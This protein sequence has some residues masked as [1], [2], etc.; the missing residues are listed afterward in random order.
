[1]RQSKL[2]ASV[3]P[4]GL[5]LA[6]LA[7]ASLLAAGLSPALAQSR[8]GGANV[9]EAEPV[10]RYRVELIFFAHSNATTTGE[11]LF[12]GV[13]DPHAPPR[14]GLL[15]MP[16]I[17]LDSLFGF[18]PIA[19]DRTG[20]QPEP[21]LRADGSG[22][23]APDGAI[24]PDAADGNAAGAAGQF[25]AQPSGALPTDSL[26]LIESAAP[27]TG[28]NSLLSAGANEVPPA[29][30]PLR[31]DEFELT[32]IYNMLR[33][34]PRYR[35]IAHTGFVQEGVEEAAAIPVDLGRLGITNP[36][37][38]VTLW[39][40]RYLHVGVDLEFYET[41]GTRWTSLPGPG[42][43]P[44]EYASAYHVVAELNAIRSTDDPRYIDHPLYG[45][46]V[47]V[48]PAPEPEESIDAEAGA[49]PA[50]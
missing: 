1:M 7:V 33:R 34:V 18:D 47:I 23:A 4:A 26:E 37:G 30:R 16:N 42:L 5:T 40:G 11:D 15:R 36:E 49:G 41:R 25:P 3:A 24:A 9:A 28:A 50:A 48:R 2:N 12:H 17:E 6:R 39:L 44:L 38:S 20:D 27:P 13:D 22:R 14:P 8:G 31:A 29:F 19:G 35:V 10:P 46:L 45:V 32:D 21:A 43:A